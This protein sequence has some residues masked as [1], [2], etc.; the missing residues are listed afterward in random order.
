[1][2]N[3]ACF[4]IKVCFWFY[5]RSNLSSLPERSS[6]AAQRG[7][8]QSPCSV[9]SRFQTSR[10]TRCR[11]RERVSKSSTGT[12]W[13]SHNQRH[14]NLTQR[15]QDAKS[16]DKTDFKQEATEATEISVLSPSSCLKFLRVWNPRQNERT[17]VA[18]VQG[19]LAV[20]SSQPETERG[21]SH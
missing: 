14:R 11:A 7:R 2:P 9:F 4:Q 19:A 10:R 17:L 8:H 5:V 3:T 6:P 15:R 21:D 1:M 18:V 16:Q 20:F 12:K 13:Q